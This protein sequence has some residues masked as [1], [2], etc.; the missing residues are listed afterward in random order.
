MKIKGQSLFEVIFAVGIAALVLTGIVSAASVAVR[1]STFSR[2][3][4]QASKLAQDVIE[5]LREERGKDWDQFATK[6]GNTYCVNDVPPT[7]TSPGV[8]TSTMTGLVFYREM[9]LTSL[10]V[11]T[12]EAEVSV[13]WA[14]ASGP[15]QVKTITRFTSWVKSLQ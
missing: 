13:N 3:N 12:V 9:K 8:C 6:A 2:N 10:D 11:N 14:D 4:A 15:H 7:F 1:N 5:W